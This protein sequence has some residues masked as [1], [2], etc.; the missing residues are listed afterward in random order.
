LDQAPI[1]RPAEDGAAITS[2][3]SGGG[4]HASQPAPNLD[5]S[6][7]VIALALVIGLILLLRWLGRRFFA[8]PAGARSS[9]AV[10]VLSRA[11]F[12][13]KQH[14]VLMQVG[15]RVL[16]VADNGQQLSS[17][18]EISDADEVAAL[19]GQLREESAVSPV[20]AFS[21]LFNRFSAGSDGVNDEA[22]EPVDAHTGSERADATGAGQRPESAAVA[23]TRAE[24][25]SLMERI[26]LV[27]RQFERS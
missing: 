26:R 1:H 11:P 24:L 9:R 22:A 13:P 15:K 18:A 4:D 2:A 8:S 19:L 6:R 5:V 21:S 17:L 27:S 7:V 23:A 16:V 25:G 20:K 12:S 3:P 10:K 14:V